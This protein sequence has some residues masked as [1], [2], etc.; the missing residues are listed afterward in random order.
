MADTPV[1]P[2]IIVKSQR[3]GRFLYSHGSET[4]IIT[5]D[6]IES[7]QANTI[8]ELIQM[9][10][11]VDVRDRGTP[12][13]Q[14]DMA[15]RG[16]SGE[17][18]LVMVNGIGVRDPQTGHFT[19]D[20]PVDLAYV[21]RIEVLSGGGSTLYGSPASGGVINIVTSND[22]MGIKG[23]IN[24]GSY[25]SADASA[26][27]GFPLRGSNISIHVR[28][29]RSD[30]DVHGTDLEYSGTDVD[31]S[32]R[33]DNL[34]INWNMG[35]LDKRFGAEGFYAPYPSFEK[36]HTLMGGVNV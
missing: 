33:S 23:G 5:R 2:E 25:G 8:A 10:A 29:G 16:S 30:G 35:F 17:G 12:G 20:I 31:G 14:S 19:M 15:I 24:A 6:D 9:I 11:S 3:S 34:N 18:V 4:H 21:E 13:S 7:F 1:M 28:G 36:T 27:I 22:F 26:G 32:Y